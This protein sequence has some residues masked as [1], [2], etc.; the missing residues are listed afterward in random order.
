MP[1]HL[2]VDVGHARQAARRLSV[3]LTRAAYLHARAVARLAPPA[4]RPLSIPPSIITTAALE[5]L[6]V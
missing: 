3:A 2:F 5:V 6:D 4:P 1:V